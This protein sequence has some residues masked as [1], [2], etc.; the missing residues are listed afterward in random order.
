MPI[1]NSHP[2]TTTSYPVNLRSILNQSPQLI[3]DFLA[4]AFGNG[5]EFIVA[6]QFYRML[7]DGMEIANIDQIALTDT[8]ESVGLEGLVQLLDRMIDILLLLILHQE[9][10]RAILLRFDP[11]DV[12]HLHKFCPLP[13]HDPKQLLLYL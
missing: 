8:Q 11:D 6:M 13:G 12:G 7:L 4:V 2:F 1:A 3:H 10:V 5:N 9:K